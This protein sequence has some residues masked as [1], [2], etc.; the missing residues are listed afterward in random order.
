[1]DRNEIVERIELL[2]RLGALIRMEAKAHGLITAVWGAAVLAGFLIFQAVELVGL[3]WYYG[4]ASLT[5]SLGAAGALTGYLGSRAKRAGY[6]NHGWLGRKVKAAWGMVALGGGAAY[7]VAAWSP[8]VSQA[9]FSALPPEAVSGLILTGWLIIDGV[10]CMVQGVIFESMAYRYVGLS[11]CGAAILVAYVGFVYAW[12]AFALTFGLGY[13][14][15]GLRDYFEFK[16]SA[17][18]GI[19]VGGG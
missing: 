6:A 9:V 14:L 2:E 10:G 8:K 11:M 5:A 4:V 19:E 12:I 7:M 17:S 3:A 15:V 16:R 1:M 13:L 18:G